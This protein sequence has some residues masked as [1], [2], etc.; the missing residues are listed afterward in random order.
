MKIRF[1]SDK[2]FLFHYLMIRLIELN[3]FYERKVI[4]AQQSW[5]SLKKMRASGLTVLVDTLKV[6]STKPTFC[7]FLI[8]KLRIIILQFQEQCACN[9]CLAISKYTG[10]NE[11]TNQIDEFPIEHIW[12]RARSRSFLR[13]GA[14]LRNGITLINHIFLKNTSLAY[15]FI[16]KLNV[17][18]G[19]GAHTPSSSS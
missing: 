9:C 4:K 12:V 14:P 6:Y 16:R 5:L 2:Q 7:V 10:N 11:R 8:L 18:S 1:W 19:R 3:F 15:K 17:T 13:R